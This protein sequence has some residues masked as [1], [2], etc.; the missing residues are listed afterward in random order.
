[1]QS[2]RA[3]DAASR[4]AKKDRKGP[5]DADVSTVPFTVAAVVAETSK[6]GGEKL[7]E[8]ESCI[9]R[10]AILRFLF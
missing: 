9:Y 7:S 5:K 1:M 6:R 3:G 10:K 2:T 4:S 8:K